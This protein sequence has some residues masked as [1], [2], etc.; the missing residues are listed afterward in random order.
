MPAARA[1]RA[2]RIVGWLFLGLGLAV[3]AGFAI[4]AGLNAS[5]FMRAKMLM[6]RNPGNSMYGL[7]FFIAATTEMALVAAAA[8]GALLALNGGT[9]LL[10]G[11]TI[12]RHDSSAG[13]TR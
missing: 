12:A 5:E 11:R 1:G 8:I 2:A 4:T 3:L 6:D 13:G 10:L 9:L 7:Q